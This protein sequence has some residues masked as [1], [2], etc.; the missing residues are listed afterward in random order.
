MK[1]ENQDSCEPPHDIC[2]RS[3]LFAVRI[4]TLCRVLSH[5]S[6][7]NEER[8]LASQLFRS[9]TSIGANIEEAQA[10][11]SK[12][13]Y[14]SKMSIACKEARETRYWLRLLAAASDIPPD[15]LHAITDEANQLIAILTTIVK[16]CRLS[17]DK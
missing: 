15:K 14:I 4:V 3:F 17:L 8:L 13:D 10:S 5:A 16:K 11:Q 12:P 7:P 9:G 6:S 1:S 2:E